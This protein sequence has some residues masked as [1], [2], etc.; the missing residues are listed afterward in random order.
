MLHGLI[1]WSVSVVVAFG[2]LATTMGSVVGGTAALVGGALAAGETPAGQNAMASLGQDIQ[3][4]FPQAGAL[5]PPT[6]RTEG[7]QVPGNLTAMAQQDSELG[8][9]LAKL[10][11]QGGASKSQADRDQVV[12]ILVTKHNLSRQDADNLV[13]QWDQQFQQAKGQASQQA[14]QEAPKAAHGLA[15]GAFWGFL[16]LFLGLLVAAWGGW[17]GTASLPRPEPAK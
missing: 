3:S 4:I 14:S 13:N 6:G 16:A 10:E 11:I 15:L 12:N 2:L 9:A 8:A 1:A 7:Q 5:L 17:A